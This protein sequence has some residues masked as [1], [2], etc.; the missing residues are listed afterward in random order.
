M[1]KFRSMGVGL[2]AVGV[3]CLQRLL[4]IELTYQNEWLKRHDMNQSLHNPT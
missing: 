4:Q 1:A 2:F 3:N